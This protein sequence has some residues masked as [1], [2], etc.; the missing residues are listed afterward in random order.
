MKFSFINPALDDMLTHEQWRKTSFLSSPPMGILYLATVLKTKGLDVSILDQSAKG[1]SIEEAVKWVRKENPDVLGFSV[2]TGTGL[3]A[4]SIANEVKKENP[5][6][7]IVFGG[8]HATLNAERILTKYPCIDIIVRGEGEYT[9]L[10]LVESLEKRNGLK[11]VLG[12]TFRQKEN[13]HSIVSTPD[14]PFIMNLDSLSF[15]NR[16][17]LNGDYHLGLAGAHVATKKFTSIISSRG[18][19][20]RCRFCSCRR[21]AHSIWRKRSVENLLEEILFLVS[22]GYKQFMFVDDSFTIDPKRVIRF[23]RMVKKERMDIEW[24]FEG[25][26]DRSSY[27]MMRE[28]VNAGARIVFFGIESANQRILDY[29]NKQITPEQSKRAIENARNAGIDVVSGSFIV[30]APSETKEEVENTLKFAQQLDL[31]IPQFNVLTAYPGT[32]LW[33]SLKMQGILDEDKYWETGAIVSKICSDTVFYEEIDQMVREYFQG[34]FT[35]PSY[36]LKQLARLLRSS[37]RCRV[38]LDNLCRA[39]PISEGL[40]QTF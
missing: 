34:F 5:D 29:Y 24:I 14:R 18:C 23:C 36:M 3:T 26:V 22:K 8:Y 15:P 33:D 30:G 28:A 10:E 9:V 39:K 17:L 20:Y 6:M 1:F 40:R 37:Y 12:V 25:R 19:P 7:K 27:G 4:A 13:S 32:D 31:D 11:N 21:M 16:D 38:V 35:R 2:L